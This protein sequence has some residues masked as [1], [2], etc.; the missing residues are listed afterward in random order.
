MIYVSGAYFY[1]SSRKVTNN[2]IYDLI[3]LIYQKYPKSLH[4]I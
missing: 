3:A 1:K 2:A 4:L